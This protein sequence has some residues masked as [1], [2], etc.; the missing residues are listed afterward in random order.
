MWPCTKKA[1]LAFFFLYLRADHHYKKCLHRV[2]FFQ[3][4][5]FDNKA[6][7]LWAVFLALR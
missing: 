7:M 5:R 6:W 3:N 4:N 1:Q 2:L